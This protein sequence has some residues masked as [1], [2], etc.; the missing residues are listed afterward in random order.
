[1][2]AYGIGTVARAFA[3]MAKEYPASYCRAIRLCCGFDILF[4]RLV[5]PDIGEDDAEFSSGGRSIS[6]NGI[7]L[8]P[9]KEQGEASCSLDRYSEG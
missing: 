1:M 4:V 8:G 2:K 5:K 3:K 7:R 6:S 9:H